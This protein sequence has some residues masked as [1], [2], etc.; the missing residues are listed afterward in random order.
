[1]AHAFIVIH[2]LKSQEEM[3]IQ[4]LNDISEVVEI[5]MLVGSYEIICKVSIKNLV[6]EAP[7]CI[8]CSLFGDTSSYW[9]TV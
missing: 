6:F 1:M 3:V 2:C 5:D 7:Y 9:S 8:N 4:H